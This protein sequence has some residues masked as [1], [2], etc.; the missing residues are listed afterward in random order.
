MLSVV[1]NGGC[2]GEKLID[3]SKIKLYDIIWGTKIV[4]YNLLKEYYE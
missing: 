4:T 2:M 1:F 3:I